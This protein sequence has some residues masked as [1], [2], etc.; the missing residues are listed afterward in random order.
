[1][2][3][4]HSLDLH[5]LDLSGPGVEPMSLALQGKDIVNPWTTREVLLQGI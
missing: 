4:V 2:W 1:M 5:V 3:G